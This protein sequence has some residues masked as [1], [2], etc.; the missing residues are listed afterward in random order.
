M[1]EVKRLFVRRYP[2]KVFVFQNSLAAADSIPW[3]DALAEGELP[4]SPA[5]E[6]DYRRYGAGEAGLA[7]LDEEWTLF[8]PHGDGR[9]VLIQAIEC[10]Q[11]VLRREKIPLGHLKFLVKAGSFRTKISLTSL[12]EPDLCASLPPF[13]TSRI[14]LL[15]N[16]RAE[17]E[18]QAFQSLLH[19]ALTSS[20]IAF[21]ISNSS[22]FHPAIPRPAYR[23]ASFPE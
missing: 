10:L 20:G 12:D 19:T 7:W 9:A 14:E 3:V 15:V 22:V 6:I 8:V 17:M 2:Q 13:Y 18:S 5:L 1:D 21:Q 4:F 11:K 23:I 16:G